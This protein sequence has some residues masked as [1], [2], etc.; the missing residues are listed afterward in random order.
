MCSSTPGAPVQHE[1]AGPPQPLST[2]LSCRETVVGQWLQVLLISF[3][4]SLSNCKR[5]APL[6]LSSRRRRSIVFAIFWS[7]DRWV[8]Q[9]VTTATHLKNPH[10]CQAD[11]MMRLNYRLEAEASNSDCFAL[12][13]GNHR[14]LART[15]HTPIHVQCRKRILYFLVFKNTIIAGRKV[16][17]RTLTLNWHRLSLQDLMVESVVQMIRTLLLYIMLNKFTKNQYYLTSALGDKT[18]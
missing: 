7:V 8:L 11:V 5:S 13:S 16:K 4:A 3:M 2:G 1:A 12:I 10:A 9:S 6:V 17:I 15:A 18:F 14:F